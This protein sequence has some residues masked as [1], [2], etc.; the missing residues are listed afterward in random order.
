MVNII[1]PVYNNKEILREGLFS[2]VNQTKRMFL[3]TLVDDCSEEDMFD[4]VEEFRKYLKIKYIRLD[5]NVGPGGARQA[6]LDS[7]NEKFFDY[8]MF[9]DADDKLYP[10]AT[11]ILYREAK[12]NNADMVISN[13]EVEG[14]CGQK[15]LLLYDNNLT[16]THGKIYRYKFLKDN[17][18][19]FCNLIKWNEDCTFNLECR[20][21]TERIFYLDE[22]T[23]LWRDFSESVTRSKTDKYEFNI[24]CAEEYI[25]GQCYAMLRVLE[26]SKISEEKK[27]EIIYSLKSIYMQ[28]QGS[29]KKMPQIFEKSEKSINELLS[30]ELFVEYFKDKK[31]VWNFISDL[32]G[33]IAI[34]GHPTVP[35]E[36]ITQWLDRYN[37]KRIK[38]ILEGKDESSSN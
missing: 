35:L 14:R 9:M 34:N 33:Y 31:L 12:V 10:R 38:N 21:M 30:N 29:I 2:L 32:P 6:G 8:V 23:Y 11:E 18:I 1:I 3:V 16:W 17:N 28:F 36:T 25:I 5:K 4:V 20:H 27:K 37:D 26:N 15:K 22:F 13:I 7:V 19:R 24:R